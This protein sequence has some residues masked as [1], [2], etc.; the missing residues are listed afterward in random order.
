MYVIKPFI[1]P[2]YYRQGGA[3]VVIVW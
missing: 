2:Y 1:K 3:M